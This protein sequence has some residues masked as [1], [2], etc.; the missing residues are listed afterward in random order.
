MDGL[1]T[2]KTMCPTS[3]GLLLVRDPASMATSLLDPASGKEIHL[4]PLAGVEDATLMHSHCLVS[5]E[6]AAPGGCVVFLVAP[7][8]D[9]FIWYCRP[10]DD[11]W[12]KHD[13]D[14]GTQIL[15]IE[16]DLY[17]KSVICPIAQCRGKFYFNP[18]DTEMGVL[19]FVPAGPVFGSVAIDDTIAADG[20]YGYE[21]EDD[22]GNGCAVYLV[23]SD[24]ELYMVTFLFADSTR[25]EIDRGSVHRMDFAERRWR[26]VSDLGGRVFLVSVFYFG[27]SCSVQGDGHE[28]RQDCVYMPGK[29]ALL[30]TIEVQKLDGAPTSDKVFWVLP[31]TCK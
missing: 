4:P 2:G 31:P 29:K 19:E 8:D 3:H 16:E 27:A 9:T 26:K 25:K 23:E 28:L 22:G 21:E 13:Y 1:L 15:D 12:V 17:E 5:G 10:G 30:G 11:D 14:I 20:S 6:P 18:G 24:G 7:G